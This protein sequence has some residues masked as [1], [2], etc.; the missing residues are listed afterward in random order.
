MKTG[1]VTEVHV[2]IYCDVCGDVYCESDGE[3]AC[4]DSTNQAVAYLSSRSAGVGWLYDG[5]RVV[6]DGCQALARCTEH[7][8][9]FPD[10]G[11]ALVRLPSK[12]TRSRTCTVCGI[13]ETE[14]EA[15][16]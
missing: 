6:C 3:S 15:L 14:I 5:D 11:R 16:S 2:V 13:C 10:P 7:G 9:T 8:H 4:F 1:L 12:T